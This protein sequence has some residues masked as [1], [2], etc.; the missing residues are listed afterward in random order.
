MQVCS[1]VAGIGGVC[2]R[3]R[4]QSSHECRSCNTATNVP[5][6]CQQPL[7]RL[8]GRL[9]QV[10]V[11]LVRQLVRQSSWAENADQPGFETVPATERPAVHGKLLRVQG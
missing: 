2:L 3:D 6:S 9:I 7:Q 4:E 5:G 1:V 10:I 11:G 8:Q